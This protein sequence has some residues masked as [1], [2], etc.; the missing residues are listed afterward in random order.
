MKRKLLIWWH[1]KR[2]YHV[3][4]TIKDVNHANT[5]TFQGYPMPKFKE[6]SLTLKCSCGAEHKV[7]EIVPIAA[8]YIPFKGDWAA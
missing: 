7:V 5:V 8:A 3:M 1:H 6:V 4:Q 2:G